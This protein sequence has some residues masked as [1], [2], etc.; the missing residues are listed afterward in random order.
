MN[1]IGT[2]TTSLSAY[3][4][5]TQIS[6]GLAA[7]SSGKPTRRVARRESVTTLPHKLLTLPSQIKDM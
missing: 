4:A 2:P 7:A 5:M 3:E 1:A 6:V